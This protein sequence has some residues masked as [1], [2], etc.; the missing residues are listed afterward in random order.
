MHVLLVAFLGVFESISI[1]SGSQAVTMVQTASSAAED[2]GRSMRYV[3]GMPEDALRWQEQLR[4]ELARLL[5]LDDLMRDRASIPLDPQVVRETDKGA[6]VLRE[7]TLRSTPKRTMRVVVAVPEGPKAPMP[8]VVGIHGHG[9]TR[10]SVFDPASGENDRIYKGFGHELAVRGC[11]VIA[12]DVGRHEV[13][14][15]GRTLMG[16]RLW[17]LMRCVDYLESLAEV[18]KAR[19]GCAGLSL[20]GEMAMWLG[21][22]D[23]R[24]AATV[25]SGFLTTMDQM[26]QNHCLCWKFDGLRSLVDWPDVY[27]LIAPRALQCQNGQKEPETD[28]CVP[29]ARQA[30]REIQPAYADLGVPGHLEL[31]VHGGGHEIDLPA[32]MAFLNAHLKLGL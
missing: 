21:A 29:L 12:T 10:M 27:S 15:E 23:T 20:G 9:G 22:M 32:L 3:P 31:D 5:K 18:D 14:E 7:V 25:S 30:L 13:Y 2:R 4:T 6:Y 28:F 26:E 11:V 24:M 8:A 19:M 1:M 17:D 16:E